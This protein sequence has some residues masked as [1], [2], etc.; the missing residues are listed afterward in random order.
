[1]YKIL[2]KSK[3]ESHVPLRQQIGMLPFLG[4]VRLG[5]VTE[6]PGA[7]ECNSIQSVKNSRDKRLMKQCFDKAGVIHAAWRPDIKTALEVGFPMVAKHPLGSK[8]TGV[9]LLK[10]KEAFDKWLANRTHENYIFE[11]FHDYGSEYRLSC[12]QDKCFF[13]VRKVL[14]KGETKNT[15][16]KGGDNTYWYGEQNPLFDKPDNWED[17]VDQACKAIKA[18]GLDL[19]CVDIKIQKN[20]DE[21]GKRRKAPKLFVVETNSAGC[22]WGDKT[23]NAHLEMIPKILKQKYEKLGD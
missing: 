21:N 23:L 6:V 1:M 18:V 14:K 11:K 10:N 3:H 2:V 17:V 4:V 22:M 19:G 20:V 16:K 8:G 5:S 13:A 12:T 15:W 7:V 9:Y